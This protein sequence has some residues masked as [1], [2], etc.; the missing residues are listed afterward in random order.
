LL[1]CFRRISNKASLLSSSSDQRKR[2]S[3]ILGEEGFS[4][5]E[6]MVAIAVLAAG[7]LPLLALQGQFVSTVERIEHAE[8]SLSAQDNAL[9]LIKSANLAQ[10]PS[11]RAI[12]EGYSVE[13]AAKAAVPPQ[14]ARG[15]GGMQGRFEMTLYD[16]DVRIIY[17]SGREDV[18]TIRELG[19]RATQGFLDGI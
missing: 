8:I 3:R 12:F 19:W 5:L 15:N 10:A 14:N 13:Y 4:V 7:L 18:F 1:H 17:V 16:V 2:N 11:G 6:A 9:N